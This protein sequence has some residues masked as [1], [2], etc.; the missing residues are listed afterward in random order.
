[1]S[2][3]FSRL[4]DQKLTCKTVLGSYSVKLSLPIFLAF[5]KVFVY[6]HTPIS[7]RHVSYKKVYCLN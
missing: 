3:L 5:F 4:F 6:F 7:Y 2:I 1:M